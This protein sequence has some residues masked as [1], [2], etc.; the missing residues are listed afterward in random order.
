ML[1]TCLGEMNCVRG[2]AGLLEHAEQNPLGNQEGVVALRQ[3]AANSPERLIRGR[4]RQLEH[5]DH[6]SG[7][8]DRG[9]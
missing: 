6:T 4:Q 8:A 3:P 9:E 7:A 1:M 2:I 5:H